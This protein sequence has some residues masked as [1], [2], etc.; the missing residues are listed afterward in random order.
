MRCIPVGILLLL[1]LPSAAQIVT[2]SITGTVTDKSGSAMAGVSVKLTSE[3]TGATREAATDPDGNFQLNAIQP[4]NYKL[5]VEHP[6]FKRYEK[7]AIELTPNEK[8]ALSA[9]SLDIGDVSESVTVKAEGVA[10]QSASGERSGV[11]TSDEIE[12]LT[13]MN[14]DFAA[15]VSLL[16][17]VVDNPG[18]AEVQGFSDNATFNVQGG[19]TN[20]NSILIDG[21]STENSNAGNPNNFVS[22]DSIQTVRI[23]VSTFQAEFGRKPGASIMAV[24][25]GGSRQYHGAAYWH[26][27]HEWMNANDFFN[28]R[29]GVA[30]TPRRVTTPGFNFGGPIPIPG[31]NRNKDKLFFFTSLEFI[32]ERRPQPIRQLLVPT[33]AERKGDFSQTTGTNLR[34]ITINDPLNGKKP[35]PDNIIP[36]NRIDPS[37]QAYLNLLPLPNYDVLAV[38]QHNYNYQIQESLNIPKVLETTRIDY[39]INPKTTLWFKLNWWREDQQG[40]A[41]SAGNANWG[42]MPSH[43]R[44]ATF[45]PVLALTRILSPSMILEGSAA[46]TRWTEFGGPLDQAAVDRLNKAKVGFNLPQLYPGN[47][48]LNLLPNVTFGGTNPPNTTLNQRF[49]LRGAETPNVYSATVTNTHGPHVTKAGLY[50]EY[51]KAIKGEYGTN[52][53][54][55]FNFSVDSNNPN[56]ANYGY[57]NSLLG[58]F[59]QYTESSSRPPLYENTTGLEWFVQD[60]WKVKRGLTLDFGARFGWSQPWHSIRRQEAGF[61][62]GLWNPAQ[63]VALMPGVR[64]NNVRQAQDPITGAIYPASIIGAIANGRGDPN[65]GTVVLSQNLSYPNGLRNNSGLKAAPRFGFAWDPFG[66]GKTAVRGGI[67]LF[68]EVH[69]RDIWGYHL[70]V[71]PPNQLNPQIWYGNV[72]TFSNIQGFQFPSNTSGMNPDR[73]LGRSINYSFGIQR[74]VGQGVLVDASYVAALGRHLMERHNINSVPL[75]TTLQPWAIDPSNAPNPLATNALRPYPGYGTI[76]WYNYDTNSSYHS[77]QVL[78]QRR[79]KHGLTGGAAW[80]WSKAMDY[81]DNDTT[82]LSALVDNRVWNYGKAGFDRTHILKLNFI[83]T[84]PKTSRYLPDARGFNPLKKAVLDGWQISGITTFMSGAPTGV[85]LSFTQTYNAN[86]WSGSP[87]DGARPTVIENP[88]LP[89]DQR[90]FNHAFNIA[91]FSFGPQGTWGNAPKD[92][93]RGPGVNNWDVSMFKNFRMA[94]KFRAE[95]RAEAYNIANHTQFSGV[96]TNAQL[97]PRTGLVG[98]VAFGQYTSTRLPRRMQLALRVSF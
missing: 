20:S 64:I 23:M 47:N 38:A 3:S 95:F 97:D 39:V 34:P 93:F 52:W 79:F 72:Q 16:P 13:V 22:M 29:N 91:A 45:A 9:I 83:Y 86:N 48:P 14:R 60:N 75:G 66:N 59:Q 69:E 73:P 58:N 55:L 77:L 90:D 51:W 17:G 25:K 96:N 62:P 57:A 6:G 94:E 11:I 27:R 42:W 12:N 70:D 92:V 43:Y 2:G 28:N 85:S 7:Q 78:V 36:A 15:L 24:S 61:V 81:T 56:D 26:Y 35:F 8:L 41:V 5:A 84:V 19:R 74:D 54:G 18:T 32:R 68:Y 21:A 87:T 63:E 37:M 46:V 4:G 65:N 44:N 88:V 10:I 80:T 31:I 82:D 30:P 40:W 76:E 98:N 33:A 67:G 1:S 49:P 53:N 89:K 71:D 50:V